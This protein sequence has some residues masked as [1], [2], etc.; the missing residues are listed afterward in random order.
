MMEKSLM[1]IIF[2]YCA[3]FSVIGVEYVIADVLHMDLV[4]YAGIPIK[5]NVF[6]F[7][8]EAALN[9]QTQMIV[10]G[11]Y[12]PVNATETFYNKVETFTTAAA[13]VAWNLILIL[14][15]TYIFNFMYLMGVP[16]VFVAIFVSLYVLLLARAI[17]GYIRGI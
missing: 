2:M 12:E 7:L 4:N 6:N 11:T 16:D 3:S 9:N 13:A 8:D 14:S 1:I 5:D 15:G 17:I 10:N